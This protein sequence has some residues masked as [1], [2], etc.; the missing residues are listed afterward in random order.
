M[1][2]CNLILYRT[3][4]GQ[5]NFKASRDQPQPGFSLRRRSIHSEGPG[6]EVEVRLANAKIVR[7][8]KV[9]DIDNVLIAS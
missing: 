7:L 4:L 9:E 2:A 3:P 1:E 8:R 6:N 5:L